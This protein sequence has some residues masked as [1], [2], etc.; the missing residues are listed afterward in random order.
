[1]PAPSFPP[2]LVP[3][4]PTRVRR[5][6]RGGLLLDRLQGAATP[7]DSHRP[8]SWIGSTTP[9]RNPGLPPEQDEGLTRIRPTG[10]TPDT[11]AAL[12]TAEPRFY[13]GADHVARLGPQLGFL[14]KLLDSAMRLHVQAHP[15]ADFARTR[16]D[17]PFGKLEVYCVLA[18]RPGIAGRI[19]LGFQRSP[20]RES[21]RRIVEDQDTA[22]MA[23]C[24]DPIEVQPGEVWIVPGGLP[25]AIG[26]GVL[27]VEVMEPSDWVVRC[28]FE[29]EGVIVP[30]GGRFM[31][32]DL[33]FCLDVFD[34]ISRSVADMRALCRLA[35]VPLSSGPGWT[36]EQLVGTERTRCFEIQRVRARTACT[37][38]GTGRGTLVIQTR[39][40][41]TVIAGHEVAPLAWGGVCFAAAAATG[42]TFTPSPSPGAG[43]PDAEWLLCRPA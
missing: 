6:Y 19:W 20:G 31:G 29:R 37:L 24:F 39:G 23:A 4:Q 12:L 32:R 3:V 40:A 42:L 28:E 21:W 17:S 26:E 5:N 18:V 35:P 10:G 33:D 38:A 30:P 16:L 25:H 15:T 27:M 1:M 9:A 34:Y 13:L 11:L 36:L 41:G 2:L 7:T 14:A 22:A 8:E 43:E